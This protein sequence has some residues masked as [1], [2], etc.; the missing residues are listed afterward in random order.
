MDS[1]GYTIVTGAQHVAPLRVIDVA[2][3]C[4]LPFCALIGSPRQ[5]CFDDLSYFLRVRHAE[6]HF[7]HARAMNLPH[8]RR[9]DPAAR[10][11]PDA[12]FG[13]TDQTGNLFHPFDRRTFTTRRQHPL[14]SQPNQRLERLLLIAALVERAMKREWERPR[15]MDELG[16]ATLIDH[17][18][19]R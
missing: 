6:V 2:A 4:Y 13:L 16:D 9:I 5:Q 10:Q 17:S 15:G 14:H 7:A 19:R 11:N 18:P 3:D 1:K 12:T 8:I